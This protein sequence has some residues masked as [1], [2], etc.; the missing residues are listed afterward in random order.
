M[1]EYQRPEDV[2]Q[3]TELMRLAPKGA[4]AFMN[5]KAMAALRAGAAVG[6]TL[7]ALLPFDEAST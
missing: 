3:A 2:V 1:S 5:L 6:Y 4:Q 7:L